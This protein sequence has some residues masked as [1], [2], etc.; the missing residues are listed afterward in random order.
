[1]GGGSSVIVF[2]LLCITFVPIAQEEE[3]K[4]GCFSFFCLTDVLFL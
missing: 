2:V 3:E 4:A 1:M